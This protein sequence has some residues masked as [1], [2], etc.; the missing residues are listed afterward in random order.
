MIMELNNKNMYAYDL[1]QIHVLLDFVIKNAIIYN[2]KKIVKIKV[3]V[4]GLTEETSFFIK[5][6]FGQIS[7]GTIAEFAILDIKKRQVILKCTG[8]KLLYFS[9][10]SQP[11]KEICPNCG[12]IGS[13]TKYPKNFYIKDITVL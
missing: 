8:C 5:K 7:K 1:G 12:A 6:Y 2:A 9:Q 10:A 11:V 3:E 13:I 4:V